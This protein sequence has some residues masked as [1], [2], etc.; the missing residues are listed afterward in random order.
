MKPVAFLLCSIFVTSST[1][2]SAHEFWL[3]A[4]PFY[5]KTDQTTEITINVGQQ[6]DGQSLPNIPAWYQGFD[7]ITGDGLKPVGGELGRDP[8]GY[9]SIKAPG[10]YAIGYQSMKKSVTLKPEKFTQYLKQEGLEKIIKRRNE[11][12]ENEKNGFELFY[13]NV[14]ALIKVG[15]KSEHN[16]YNYDFNHP[17]NINPLQNPYELSKGDDL[18]VQLTFKQK[19]AANLL[20]HGKIKNKPA[21]N[22][23]VR[24]DEK[25]YAIMPIEHRGVWLLHTVEMIRSEQQN[26]DWESYW[27]SLTFEIR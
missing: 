10:I 16:F 15:D 3:E 5:Q 8:A 24:T 2:V 9:V 25:G 26:I 12:N 4:K 22:L 11:L 7:A 17:L 27:A 1:L 14:K 18:R 19:P 21:F 13:R 6:M 23:S 20:L